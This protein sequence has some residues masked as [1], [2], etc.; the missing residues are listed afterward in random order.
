MAVALLCVVWWWIL[1]IFFM[2]YQVYSGEKPLGCV[3]FYLG[4]NCILPLILLPVF[5]KTRPFEQYF[6]SV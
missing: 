1:E 2:V 6:L 4:Q 3:V 5:H